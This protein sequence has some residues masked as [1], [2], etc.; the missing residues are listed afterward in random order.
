MVVADWLEN[1]W[2]GNSRFEIVDWRKKTTDWGS[3]DW[4]GSRLIPVATTCDGRRP[5]PSTC[6]GET[7]Q[8][9]RLTV[10][11]LLVTTIRGYETP[12]NDPGVIVASFYSSTNQKPDIQSF[13]P[14]K[15]QP[16]VGASPGWRRILDRNLRGDRAKFVFYLNVTNTAIV[17]VV[18]VSS[19]TFFW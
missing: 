1:E 15:I 16:C 3:P 9:W 13:W 10:G 14:T 2:L 5:A 6:W 17:S 18:T 11:I 19:V 12:Y 8:I 7:G 4:I